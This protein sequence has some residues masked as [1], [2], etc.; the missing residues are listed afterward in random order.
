M[1]VWFSPAAV[2]EVGYLTSAAKT[3]YAR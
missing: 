3:P 1:V 2:A